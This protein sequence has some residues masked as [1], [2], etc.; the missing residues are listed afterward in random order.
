MARAEG[1][2]VIAE[3]VF[4]ASFEIVYGSRFCAR[5]SLS[6]ALALCV[7]R[8]RQECQ[9][10]LSAEQRSAVSGLPTIREGGR[11]RGKRPA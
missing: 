7:V 1:F 11:S 5:S 10:L 3:V 8:L 6:N 4:A 9:E 2:A